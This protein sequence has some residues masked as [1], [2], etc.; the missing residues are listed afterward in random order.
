MSLQGSITG[1]TRTSTQ[2]FR[3]CLRLIQHIAGNSAKSKQLRVIVRG[4]FKRNAR[5]TDPSTIDNLKS[6]AIRALSNYMMMES[7]NKDAKFKE[8]VTAFVNKEAQSIK[9]GEGEDDGKAK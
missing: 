9:K 6:N 5:V 2:L 4:E 3:D 8:K 1:I 7:A